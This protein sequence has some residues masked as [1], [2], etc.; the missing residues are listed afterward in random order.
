MAAFLPSTRADLA[1]A[2]GDT[3]LPSSDE[4]YSQMLQ[5]YAPALSSI[6]F[7]GD[8]REKYEQKKAA[9]ANFTQLYNGASSQ[10]LKNLYGMKIRVLQGE[11]EALEEMAGEERR[12]GMFT[13]G[14]KLGG[15]LLLVGGS[16]ATVM[17]ANYFWQK[18]KTEKLQQGKLKMLAE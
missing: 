4:S 6:L 14:T 2:Y 11:I 1:D 18:S 5:Q 3:T 16:V 10:V 9:L 8:P 12:A 15:I 13:Q 17:V 7:G